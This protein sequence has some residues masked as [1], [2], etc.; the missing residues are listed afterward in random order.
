MVKRFLIANKLH[1]THCI[2]L[3]HRQRELKIKHL[4]EP[5][6]FLKNSQLYQITC[7]W[8][9]KCFEVTFSCTL[10]AVVTFSSGISVV[11]GDL[12]GIWDIYHSIVPQ[13]QW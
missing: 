1:Q 11:H 12:C 13:V 10:S 4:K 7:S 9:P 5:D 3:D 8:Y 6:I 2:V